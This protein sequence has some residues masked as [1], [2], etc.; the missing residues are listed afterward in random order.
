ML[1]PEN[2]DGASVEENRNYQIQGFPPAR[3]RARILFHPTCIARSLDRW[4][5]ANELWVR[6]GEIKV[7]ITEGPLGT[8]VLYRFTGDLALQDFTLSD[9]FRAY[10]RKLEAAGKLDHPFTPREESKLRA[11]RYLLRPPTQPAAAN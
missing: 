4:S 9:G 3:E 1:D 2:F 10:H 8:S 5:S 7:A 11:L 6:P